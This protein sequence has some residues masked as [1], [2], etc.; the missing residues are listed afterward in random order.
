[1]HRIRLF[2][3]NISNQFRWLLIGSRGGSKSGVGALKSR[4]CWLES[5]M[6]LSGWSAKFTEPIP[7]P[8]GTP[9]LI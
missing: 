4:F 8:K 5:R 9:L 7:L 3:S 1:V 6:R 2:V